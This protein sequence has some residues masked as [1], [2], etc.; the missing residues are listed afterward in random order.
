MELFSIPLGNWYLTTDFES[1]RYSAELIMTALASVSCLYFLS[2]N[3]PMP[4]ILEVLRKVEREDESRG[5][6]ET[7]EGSC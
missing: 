2:F 1:V 3:T 7:E 4:D 5:Q 6:A